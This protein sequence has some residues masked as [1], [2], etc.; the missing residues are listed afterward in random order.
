MSIEGGAPHTMKR[1]SK[2]NFFTLDLFEFGNLN[3]SIIFKLFYLIRWTLLPVDIVIPN[4][5]PRLYCLLRS[6]LK[7]NILI[8]PV[9]WLLQNGGHKFTILIWPVFFNK[10]LSALDV[11]K[12]I[13]KIQ[14][15]FFFKIYQI[16]W[17]C[18][19]VL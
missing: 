9:S 16:T 18:F 17:I 2:G 1:C 3:P 10:C 8:L 13:R 15:R 4:F 19:K 11:W 14:K 7:I 6:A 12:V 5:G